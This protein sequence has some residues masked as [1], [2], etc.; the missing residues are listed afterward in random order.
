MENPSVRPDWLEAVKVLT[1]APGDALFIKTGQILSPEEALGVRDV[2][3][4]LFPGRK[5]LVSPF[6]V[7]VVRSI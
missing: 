4:G 7:E 5:V 6:D 1:L 2:V 3:S